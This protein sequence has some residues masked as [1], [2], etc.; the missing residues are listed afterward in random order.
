MAARQWE[1]AEAYHLKALEME[2]G[3]LGVLIQL[4]ELYVAT[5]RV[6]QAVSTWQRVLGVL[7]LPE[8][9]EE[10]GRRFQA[11]G[12][13]GY[14]RTLLELSDEI[15]LDD[16]YRA[17]LHAGLGDKE[18]AFRL[19]ESAIDRKLNGTSFLACW[20]VWDPIRDDPRFDDLVARL[21]IPP[22]STD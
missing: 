6:D 11:E 7:D 2:P 1:A 22:T 3:F 20:P 21:D 5:G 8:Q 17:Y 18:T 15:G 14:F 13:D 19:L 16:F 9:A 12:S 10:I 4:A